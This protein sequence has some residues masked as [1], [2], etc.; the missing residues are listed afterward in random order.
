MVEG[1]GRVQV[2]LSLDVLELLAVELVVHL[3]PF[4]AKELIARGHA[5]V[6]FYFILRIKGALLFK[7]FKLKMQEEKLESDERKLAL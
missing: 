2:D 3:P 1:V 4:L 5:S 7:Y 6:H